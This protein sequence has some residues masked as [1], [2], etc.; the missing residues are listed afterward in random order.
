MQ[1]VTARGRLAIEG[2]AVAGPFEIAQPL[3]PVLNELATSAVKHGALS[4]PAGSIA[5]AWT[6]EPASGDLLMQWRQR[7]GPVVEPP[8]R[9][10]LGSRLID[11]AIPGAA[12]DR[13]FEPAG[14]A[15]TIRSPAVS[16]PASTNK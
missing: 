13:R 12:A 6:V 4:S 11:H 9:T 10:G 1:D 8:T 3:A 15:C 7:E 14:F 2:E 5:L 16:V